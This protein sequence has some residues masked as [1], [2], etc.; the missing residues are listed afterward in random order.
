MQNLGLTNTDFNV[1]LI[2]LKFIMDLANSIKFLS[3][4]VY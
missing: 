1:F 4:E 3:F 2:I